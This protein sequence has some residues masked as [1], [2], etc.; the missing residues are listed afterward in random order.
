MGGRGGGS[1]FKNSGGIIDRNAPTRTIEKA[2][3][4][5]KKVKL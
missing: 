4:R 2:I 1:G 5:T 3:M